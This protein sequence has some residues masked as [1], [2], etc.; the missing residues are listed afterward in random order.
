MKNIA[1]V[2]L[3]RILIREK[4]DLWNFLLPHFLFVCVCFFLYMIR[5]CYDLIKFYIENMWLDSNSLFWKK[6]LKETVN[7]WIWLTEDLLS[8]KILSLPAQCIS[9]TRKI[10]FALLLVKKNILWSSSK[11]ALLS[12]SFD[13][14]FQAFRGSTVIVAWLTSP[15]HAIPQIP[16]PGD[17]ALIRCTEFL[18]H[19]H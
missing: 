8:L 15:L 4:D 7:K 3:L 14:R 16:A 13:A 18:S 17:T 9:Y 5:N 2:I 1:V 11:N 19:D 6:N 10:H 12:I